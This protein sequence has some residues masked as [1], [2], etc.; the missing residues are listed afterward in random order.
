MFNDCIYTAELGINGNGDLKTYYRMI[1]LAVKHKFDY[2]KFQKRNIDLCYT[3]EYLNASRESP[4]GTTQRDQKLG[5]ELS[6][7]D[8]ESID[9]YCKDKGIG[10]YYSAWDVDSAEK[11]LRFETDYIKIARASNNNMK[12]LDFYDDKDASLIVAVGSTDT[13]FVDNV[14]SE[15][16][17]IEYLLACR[18]SY[19]TPNNFNGFDVMQGLQDNLWNYDIG[20]SNH[21]PYWIYP[22]IASYLDAKMIEVHI[23]LDKSM[24]GSDQKASL[25]DND[26]TNMFTFIKR[27]LPTEVYNQYCNDEHLVLKK[28]RQTW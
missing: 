11:M 2:V 10:W 28:L 22:V 24:Y 17:N 9:A 7:D 23:T 13:N 3:Q 18:S 14:L 21:S 25:D 12:L 19:P 27:P 4:W 16:D 26:L 8:F 5:L 20:F 1:D 6:F 15:K